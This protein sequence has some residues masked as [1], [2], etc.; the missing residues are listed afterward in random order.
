VTVTTPAVPSVTT[1]T[2][3]VTTTAT[4][5]P[6]P[7]AIPPAA[8]AR[9][10]RVARVA[11]QTP[12]AATGAT[13]STAP[14][15]ADGNTCQTGAPRTIA[16]PKGNPFASNG[17]WIWQ[18]GSTQHGS[19]PGI[20]AQARQFGLRTVLIK[21]GDGTTWWPQFNAATVRTLHAWGLHVCAWQFVYGIHPAQ[22][23]AIGARAVK[24]GADC[25]VIDAESQ[26]QGLYVQAQSYIS[27]LRA[28]IG[29]RF[30][31]ALAGFPYIDYHPSFPYSVFLGPNG[32]QYNVPQMYWRDIGTTVT[33][34]YSHTYAFNRLYQ[35]PIFPLGQVFDSPPASQINQF[36]AIAKYYGATGVSWWD[37][38]SAGASEFKAVWSPIGS[39]VGFVPQRTV[40]SI[41]HG[42]KGDVVVWAQEHLVTAGQRLAVDGDFGQQ[43]RRAVSRFQSTHGLPTNGVIGPATWNALLR[44][45]PQSIR[46]TLKKHGLSAVVARAGATTLPVPRS[47]SLAATRNELGGSPGRGSLDH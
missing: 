15:S 35:R 4:P 20:G 10:Q 2:P 14:T 31:V 23:A 32:A 44:Y 1:T 22:E 39:I 26:Y 40:A 42:A 43:T 41:G 9:A 11:I 6:T 16:V 37:W 47:A 34:V 8:A 30:P 5:I 25:L 13:T 21:A 3:A 29:A 18:M 7:I 27:A 17:M 45:Q 24:T 38:Q 36:R 33:S 46:W 28:Q 19:A 12:T